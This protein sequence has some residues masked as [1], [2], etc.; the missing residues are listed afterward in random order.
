MDSNAPKFF[1]EKFAS[2]AGISHAVSG[3]S[4]LAQVVLGIVKED[5]AKRVA[6]GHLPASIG[7]E[8][9]AVC[10]SDGIEVIKPPFDARALPGA[11]D[12]TPVG[13]SLADFAV[14]ESGSLVELVT[15]DAL[16][17]VSSLP[18]LHIGIV[19]ADKILNTLKDA[20]VP[21]REFYETHPTHATATFISGP[22]R[23]ADIE[24]RL[25]LGVHGPEAAHVIIVN[26]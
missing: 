2:L 26:A 10:A 24:M 18:R 15:D 23:T 5:D 11:I 19:Y 22:S 12:V 25:T 1:A 13:I 9:E 8:V 16:R 20:A 17:L 4:E 6:L 14:A 21:L 3:E 7:T